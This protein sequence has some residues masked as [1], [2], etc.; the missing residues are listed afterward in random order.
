MWISIKMSFKFASRGPNNH[1]PTLVQIMTWWRSCDKRLS[2]PMMVSFFW[3]IYAS[4]SQISWH[5]DGS[6]Y[7]TGIGWTVLSSRKNWSP[8]GKLI[9]DMA[10]IDWHYAYSRRSR[11]ADRITYQRYR[12]FREYL[13]A[14]NS[15]NI[16]MIVIFSQN[17]THYKRYM[18]HRSCCKLD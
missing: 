2:D 18:W 12:I 3:R 7:H 11:H 13:K 9:N 14:C 1:I 10:K 16:A 6:K 8:F 15:Y 4:L 5:G 17:G